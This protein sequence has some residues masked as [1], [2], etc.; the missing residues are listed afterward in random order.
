M[1]RLL[2]A[3]SFYSL[4]FLFIMFTASQLLD[5]INNHISEI[6]FTRTPK[7]L[8]EPIEYILS[9]GGKR[10]RPVLMLMGYNL[11]R[12][13]LRLYTILPLRLKFTTINTLLHDDLMDCADMRR[14]KPTVHKVWDENTAIL[15]GDAMLVL[16]YRLM[17]NCPERYLKQVMDIFSQTALE[18]CEGQQWDMEFETRNDVT[19]PEYME[20]IR[21]KTSVLLSA[22]LKIGAVLGGASED[23]ARKLYDFGI[24]MGLAFQLQDDY[25]DVYGDSKVFGKNIGGDILCNKKT[26]MLINALALADGIQRKEL[27]KWIASIAFC[28]E[29]KIKSCN[30]SL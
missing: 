19:V 21:L 26:F 17:N 27:E 30:S 14:N 6:Q 10:I 22:A 16:A 20:M 7:G 12:E 15:S 2:S 11:Y 24:K 25:L 1:E 28:P 18:I 13:M 9:L 8:Y 29:E 4:I 3:A 23:D 5:K